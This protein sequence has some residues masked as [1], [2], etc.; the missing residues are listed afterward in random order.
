MIVLAIETG[1][2]GIAAAALE[3][4]ASARTIFSAR[5][6]VDR[7]HAARLIP[8]LE[9]Q[10]SAAGLAVAAIALFA[11]STGPGSFTGLRVGLAA[12]AGLAL[13]H[14]RPIVGISGFDAMRATADAA[15][16]LPLLTALDGR[17]AEPFTQLYDAEGQPLGAP[18]NP[19]REALHALLP[20]GRIALCGDGARL[21]QAAL[22]ERDDLL[23]HP[24][25]IDPVALA[26]LGHLRRGEARRGPPPPLYVRPPD[27]RKLA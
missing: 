20:E 25:P 11:G 22:P 18:A 6:D 7:G 4:G 21:V 24:G 12:L 23:L 2:A 8:F 26:R 10:L 1:G 16:G 14:D 27:A 15:P 9:E 17:R 13:A 3:F 5:E 19:D